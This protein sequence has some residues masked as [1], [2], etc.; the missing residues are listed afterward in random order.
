MK[1]PRWLVRCTPNFVLGPIRPIAGRFLGD[2][3]YSRDYYENDYHVQDY[4]LPH[5][6]LDY[7]MK[8][9]V[10]AGQKQKLY[11]V[12][13]QIEDISAPQN[14]LEAGCAFGKTGFWLAE[15][16][17]QVKL[18]M[19]DFAETAVDFINKN[20]PVPE[21]TV[22]WRGDITEIRNGECGFDNFFDFAS[23]L[24]VTEHLPRDIYFMCT[25]ELYRVI[26]PGG[27]LLLKQ[28]NE[29]LREHINIRWEWQ[30]VRDFKKAGF[31]LDRRL[32]NRHYLMSKPALI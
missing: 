11:A 22:V 30:L 24:D 8:R 7:V 20:N 21:R 12:L 32:P 2:I 16:Y 18:F 4:Q 9:F 5:K 15:Y 1:I 29:V 19:F 17:A 10:D 14:W 27:F 31:C 6:S 26:R 13:D 25:H 28:G 3:D 23:L